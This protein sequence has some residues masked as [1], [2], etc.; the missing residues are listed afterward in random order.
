MRKT[1]SLLLLLPILFGCQGL[2][3]RGDR[4]VESGELIKAEVCYENALKDGGDE[5]EAA[6][7]LG[8]LY[9]CREGEPP[10]HYLKAADLFSEAIQAGYDNAV[11]ARLWRA[12]AYLRAGE[13]KKGLEDL[14]YIVEREPGH[15]QARLLRA[16]CL[17]RLNRGEEAIADLKACLEKEEAD[18]E[19]LIHVNRALA[20]E[21]CRAGRYPQALEAWA[22]LSLLGGMT[23][24]DW[25]WEGVS[26][27]AVK[28]FQR[29]RSAWS[30]L[31]RRKLDEVRRSFPMA[32]AGSAGYPETAKA[33]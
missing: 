27:Y 7:R 4:Y 22:R 20:V 31:P 2:V 30:H 26:A 1:E 33:E 15:L 24:T 32:Y 19:W 8:V 23:E 14:D 3:E 13:Y 25:Y 6:Y 5:G 16:E 12:E 11:V 18:R 28:D 9:L 29:A 17:S 21:F 10:E